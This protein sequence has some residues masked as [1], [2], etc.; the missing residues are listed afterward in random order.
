M[1]RF[2]ALKTFRVSDTG[3]MVQPGQEFETKITSYETRGLAVPV[4]GQQAKKPANKKTATVNKAV[5]SGPL[6]SPGGRTGAVT[7][8]L[9]SHQVQAPKTRRSRTFGGKRG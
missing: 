3:E 2:K 9:L 1:A 6:D 5:D 4:G 8:P 7:S